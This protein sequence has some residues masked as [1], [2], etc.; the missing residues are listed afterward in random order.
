MQ[1]SDR[2]TNRLHKINYLR[3]HTSKKILKEGKEDVHAYYKTDF[4]CY[5]SFCNKQK[6][7]EGFA[8]EIPSIDDMIEMLAV[9]VVHDENVSKLLRSI[10]SAYSYLSVDYIHFSTQSPPDSTR[11]LSW[12]RKFG[13]GDLKELISVSAL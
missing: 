9:A 1:L 11:Q 7:T 13:S 6:V 8:M 12:T 10:K 3:S 4:G 5:C 2:S